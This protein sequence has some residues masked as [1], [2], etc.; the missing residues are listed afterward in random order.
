V[1]RDGKGINGKSILGVMMLAAS[2][3]AT[4]E[5]STKGPEADEALAALVALVSDGFGEL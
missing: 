4:I 3:G 1:V 2:Q 5:I